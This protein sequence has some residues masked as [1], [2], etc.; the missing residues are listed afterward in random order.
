MALWMAPRPAVWIAGQGPLRLALVGS[1][2]ASAVAGPSWLNSSLCC[3]WPWLAQPRHAVAG[4]VVG[5]IKASAVAGLV[6]GLARACFGWPGSAQLRSLL[7][8]A[9]RVGLAK[10]AGLV[11]AAAQTSTLS[12]LLRSPTWPLSLCIPAFAKAAACF[13]SSWLGWLP[14]LSPEPPAWL[15]L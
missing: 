4:P 15:K 7:W 13:P 11:M 8:L 5:P 9:P 1:A 10:L 2:K 12:R 14:S 6:D 3:G